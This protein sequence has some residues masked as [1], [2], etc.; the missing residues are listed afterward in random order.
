MGWTV[1][2]GI[3]E[4][5]SAVGRVAKTTARNWGSACSV[6]PLSDD[7]WSSTSLSVML[8][9]AAQ[10]KDLFLLRAYFCRR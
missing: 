5:Q 7:S 4:P 6:S 8:R 1:R 9:L 10:A 3:R 2:C